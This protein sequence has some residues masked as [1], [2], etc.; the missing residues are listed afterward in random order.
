MGS[1]FRSGDDRGRGGNDVASDRRPR[2]VVIRR[3]VSR[4]PDGGSRRKPWLVAKEVGRTDRLRLPG[5]LPSFGPM[6]RAPSRGVTPT[7][8][9]GGRFGGPNLPYALAI[10]SALAA[11]I[12][13]VIIAQPFSPSAPN[14]VVGTGDAA[15]GEVVFNSRCQV[16]HGPGGEGIVG[17]GKP[18]TTSEFVA[19]LTDDGL[20]AFLNVGRPSDDPLN[21]TGV[22]MPAR[23]G[24]PPL[25]DSELVDV[26]AYL[27]AINE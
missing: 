13:F 1:K 12:P 11:L 14:A 23:G 21:T 24:T 8:G 2:V 4:P 20:L 3:I 19:G 6:T 5:D 25:T 15:Q 16:C 18:L 9:A 10:L 27:R 22:A 26:L 17:L 7:S